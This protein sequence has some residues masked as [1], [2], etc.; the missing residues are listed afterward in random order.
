MLAHAEGRPK[1]R[2]LGEGGNL[3]QSLV[4]MHFVPIDHLR[5]N[6]STNHLGGKEWGFGG[7]VSGLVIHIQKGHPRVLSESWVRVVL[8][9]KLFPRTQRVEGFL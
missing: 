5:Q 6:S 8:C 2:G 7:S 3:N 4:N 9:N 1:L